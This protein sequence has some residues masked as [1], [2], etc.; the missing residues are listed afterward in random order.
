MPSSNT[1]VQAAKGRLCKMRDLS[2]EG[3]RGVIV[4]FS[5]IV[6]ISGVGGRPA[7]SSGCMSLIDNNARTIIGE[8]SGA[9]RRLG[10][11]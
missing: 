4:A 8:G 3:Q 10:A 6:C 1:V 11:E 7:G 9:M 2:N 5:P